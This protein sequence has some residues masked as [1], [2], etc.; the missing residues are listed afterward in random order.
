MGRTKNVKNSSYKTGR[1]VTAWRTSALAG[2][3]FKMDLRE[4]G[5]GA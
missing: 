2:G 1:E 3:Y 4:I 5:F